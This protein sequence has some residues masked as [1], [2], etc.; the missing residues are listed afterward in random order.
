MASLKAR[1]LGVLAALATLFTLYL[2]FAPS[3]P[4]AYTPE[5]IN[6]MFQNKAAEVPVR[7]V[8]LTSHAI[9]S[10]FLDKA[11]RRSA[12]WNLA[13]DIIV[14]NGKHIS[15]TSDKKHQASNMFSK[16]PLTAESFEMEVTFHIH[17][18]S[19]L[20]ADGMAVWF[21]EEPSPVG[22]VFGAQNNFKGLAIMIDTFRNG[23]DGD[24]P[25]VSAQ[26]ARSGMLFYDKHT[27]GAST[28]LAS[29][30]AKLLVNP[31]SGL[32]RMRIVHTKNGYLSVDFNYDPHNSDK[33]HNCFTLLDVVL[34]KNKYLGFSA[35]TGEVTENVDIIESKIYALYAPDSDH[36]IESVHELETIIEERAPPT[37]QKDKKAFKRA[38][39][40]VLR[41][42]NAER[43]IKERE[44]LERLQ[45]YGDAD[46][47]FVRRWWRRFTTTIKYMLYLALVVF[48]VWIARIALKSRKGN[49]R[50]RST[51]LLD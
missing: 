48:L 26:A 47:T 10:P 38:R 1:L 2:L 18:E 42:K 50:Y 17:A 20:S 40:L 35:E 25:L 33:W 39:R 49:R 14:E 30:T 9:T 22:D 51:G 31:S 36:Y 19:V 34:S 12:N 23:R 27:D 32:S 6:D 8:E 29:C 37:E 45:K 24:F 4:E 13:G 44:K 7:K 46:A 5:E 15:L 28:M 11:T 21:T 43:R 3:D 16:E 41:L